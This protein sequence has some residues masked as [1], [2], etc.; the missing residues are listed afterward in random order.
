[1]AVIS[2]TDLAAAVDFDWQALQSNIQAVRPGMQVI[3]VSAKTG[4]GM[5]EWL[6]WLI[7]FR[8]NT[9]GGPH[10]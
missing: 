5:D 7:S 8:T 2:K 1:V 10:G 4:Q 6:E 3:K 9:A